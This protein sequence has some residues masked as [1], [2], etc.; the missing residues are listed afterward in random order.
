[1]I[2]FLLP[3]LA[4][5]LHAS[6]GTPIPAAAPAA[7][8]VPP[9]TSWI[10]APWFTGRPDLSLGA[11]LTTP[12]LGAPPQ[13]G[14][15]IAD[16]IF[17]HLHLTQAWG[18]STAEDPASLI[19]GAHDPNAEGWTL[20]GIEAESSFRFSRYLEAFTGHHFYWDQLG[21]WDYEH[22]ESF[23]KLLNLPGGFELRAGQ[24]FNRFGFHN[25]LHL[26][27]WDFTDNFLASG[28]L[29]GDHP[30]TTVGAEVTW[31]LPTP[32]QSALSVS[33][34]DA[35]YD[36]H[37]HDHGDEAH[38][39]HEEAAFSPE[40][41]AFKGLLI[42]ANWTNLIQINDFHRIRFGAATAWGDNAA[43]RTSS[44]SGLH[45]EYEWRENGLEPGGDYFRWRSEF[46]FRSFG[47]VSS[48]GHSDHADEVDHHG[49][50]HHDEHEDDHHGEHEDDHHDEHGED[51][52]DEHGDEHGDEG[53]ER[54]RFRDFGFYTYALYGLQTGFAG[55]LELG[56]RA[57]YTNAVSDAGLPE[58]FRLTPSTRLFLN[59]AATVSLGVQYNWDRIGSQRD[60]HSVWTQFTFDW[61]GPEVR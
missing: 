42:S 44:V 12:Q 49:E 33:V 37:A 47:S 32:F 22:D 40:S 51:H 45:A 7:P 56:L 60:E 6:A 20:Q 57:D 39:D 5:I 24:Y 23:L 16:V 59:K 38:G 30:L 21:G 18:Q 28:R 36:D 29:L 31:N 15:N 2:R 53:E 4:A 9:A 13:R 17:P 55:P 8:T 25:A 1:M 48:A 46:L 52:H 35:Q 54:R 3:S 26:H 14:L 41:A 10:N 19:S 50:D 61:G 11:P 58:R 27:G 34:G 43:N